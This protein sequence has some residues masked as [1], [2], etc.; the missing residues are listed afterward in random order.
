MDADDWH[1]RHDDP[2]RDPPWSYLRSDHWVSEVAD[3]YG[4]YG[5]EWFASVTNTRELLASGLLRDAQP[6]AEAFARRF[7]RAYET[8]VAGT[9]GEDVLEAGDWLGGVMARA[10]SPEALACN[11]RS[12][13][14]NDAFHGRG[15]FMAR[16]YAFNSMLY[17]AGH[18]AG[19]AV[20]LCTLGEQLLE[21]DALA[22]PYY[23]PADHRGAQRLYAL[24]V[25]AASATHVDHPRASEW[26]SA[27]LEAL[28]TAPFDLSSLP[29]F[30]RELVER[31]RAQGPEET[32]AALRHDSMPTV[33]IVVAI[34]GWTSL[35]ATIVFLVLG[36]WTWAVASAVLFMLLS[37]PVWKR[38]G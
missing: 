18:D 11:W 31:L 19:A 5:E 29:P 28:E 23:D 30:V 37:G 24:V 36:K 4:P 27:A 20:V 13:E 9:K 38:L 17:E 16:V 15:S 21:A 33:A 34:A 35:A 3:H 25:L 6:Q 10:G 2:D 22:P 8:A 26:R 14:V 1:R 7:W 32:P 12:A